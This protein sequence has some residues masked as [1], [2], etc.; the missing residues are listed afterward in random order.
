MPERRAIFDNV[1][2]AASIKVS[3]NGKAKRNHPANVSS[4]MSGKLSSRIRASDM[5]GGVPI[6]VDIPPIDAA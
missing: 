2:H 6:S 4:S 3:D 1:N 5:L